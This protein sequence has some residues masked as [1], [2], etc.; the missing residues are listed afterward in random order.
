MPSAFGAR[1]GF[2]DQNAWHWCDLVT[3]LRQS[4]SLGALDL[5]RPDGR[6]V[7]HS[8]MVCRLGPTV[9]ANVVVS[10][11][12]HT[13]G[14]V[15]AQTTGMNLYWDAGLNEVSQSFIIIDRV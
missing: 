5:H 12:G 2:A 13:T 8:V 11:G 15:R 6:Q 4:R 3:D 9:L 14:W 1:S 10:F 7:T